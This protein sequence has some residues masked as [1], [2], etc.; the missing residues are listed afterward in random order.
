VCV[1]DNGLLQ[2]ID[3]SPL[4][5][6]SKGVKKGNGGNGCKHKLTLLQG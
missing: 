2:V 1:L 4:N 6:T 5:L 3:D